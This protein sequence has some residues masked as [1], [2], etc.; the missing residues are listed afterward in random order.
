MRAG[1]RNE[2]GETARHGEVRAVLRRLLGPSATPV[3]IVALPGLS[4]ATY[5]VRLAADDLVVRLP[6]PAAFVNRAAEVANLE[7]VGRLGIGP[8][9]LAADRASGVLV[10][11][12]VL[13]KALDG[14]SLVRPGM[15]ER[16]AATL[17]RLHDSRTPF[18]GRFDA[19]RAIEGYAA[20][21]AAQGTAASRDGAALA[22]SALRLC[23]RLAELGA[24]RRPCHNDLVPANVIVDGPNLVLIDWEYAAPND[25]L[26][27]L[28]YLAVEAPLD[29]A[30][31]QRLSA[32][33]GVDPAGAR[34]LPPL[35]AVCLALNGLWALASGRVEL[36][37]MAD[38]RLRRFTR[39]PARNIDR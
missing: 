24:P 23:R 21:L 35:R 6:S 34:R 1:P 25:P 8:R 17:R 38:D 12:A 9:L 4:N 31:E 20:L 11:R 15:V 18:A 30:A 2:G 36:A 22:G 26:W 19:G 27:D 16:L 5:R 33:Y 37:A 29:A 7:A 3:S 32:A 28:A 13:G 39:Y 10:Y 14:A